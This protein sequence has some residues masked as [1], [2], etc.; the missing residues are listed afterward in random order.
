VAPSTSNCRR[1]CG[2]GPAG[3]SARRSKAPNVRFSPFAASP[4]LSCRQVGSRGITAARRS[5]NP[6]VGCDR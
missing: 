1:R 6:I 5:R 2:A 3:I 4:Q